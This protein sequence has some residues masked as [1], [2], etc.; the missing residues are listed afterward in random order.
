MDKETDLFWR[1]KAKNK[2]QLVQAMESEL[3]LK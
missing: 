1:F 2:K 3:M